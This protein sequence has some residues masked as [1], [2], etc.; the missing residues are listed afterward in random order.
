M[1]ELKT[2]IEWD[3]KTFEE[4]AAEYKKDVE[5]N[6]HP[7]NTQYLKGKADAYDNAASK[8]KKALDWY[9]GE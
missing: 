4:K 3:I 8:L 2:V 7:E 9:F 1:I 5:E 6:R